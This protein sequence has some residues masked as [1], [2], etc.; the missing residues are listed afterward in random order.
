MGSLPAEGRQHSQENRMR[1]VSICGSLHSHTVDFLLLL[2]WLFSFKHFLCFRLRQQM[3]YILNDFGMNLMWLAS[4]LIVVKT[5]L[6]AQT[7]KHLPTMWETWVWSLGQ[8]DPL[9]KEVATHSTVL[10][11]RIPWTEEPGG[12]QF[13]GSQRVGLHW[14]TKL[15]FLSNSCWW[16]YVLISQMNGPTVWCIL[17]K[18]RNTEHFF[19][20]NA[21]IWVAVWFAIRKPCRWEK[22]LF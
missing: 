14:A 15:F 3:Q 20:A 7:V 9:V 13:M 19:W 5:S 21:N 17:R 11:W 4:P 18:E 22:C 10:A 8:E 2:L 16:V 12:L 1:Q 6:V